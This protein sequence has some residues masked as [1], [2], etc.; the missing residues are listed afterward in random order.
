MRCFLKSEN[1]HGINMNLTLKCFATIVDSGKTYV[2]VSAADGIYAAL[3]ISRPRKFIPT[4][5][6]SW[7]GDANPFLL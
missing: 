6:R 7:A 3:L 2:A 1:D 4:D 5:L